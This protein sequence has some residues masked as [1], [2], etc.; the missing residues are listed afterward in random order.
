MTAA[1]HIA[2]LGLGKMGIPMVRNLLGSGYAV[3]VYNRSPEPTAMLA[4]EGAQL[5]SSPAEAVKAG[6]IAIT[7]LA[8]DAALQTVTSGS[9]GL[10]AGL[11]PGGLHIS[12]STVSP[13]TSRELAA[14]HDA[15]A[16]Q[17]LTAPVF[18]RPEAA[19]ARK[20]WI[21]QSGSQA[22]KTRAHPLLQALGQGI[23]DFGDAPEA[24]SVVKLAGNFMILSAIEAM[25]EAFALAEKQG[26]DRQALSALFGQ[27]LF[28][29]PVYQNYGRILAERAYTP[30]GF[31]LELGMKDMRL[32]RDTAEQ[33]TVTMP[34]ADL[35]HARLLASLAKGRAD[36]DWTAIELLTAEDAALR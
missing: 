27:T 16:C 25:S 21:C 33:A 35:L 12:M 30:A 22:A 34:L 18:G 28:A 32:V 29:C 26:I 3:T 8:N 6:G 7:M 15:A 23:F 14:Q 17:F 31:K 1:P 4:A 10:L 2:F 36:M 24:A 19:A 13:D 20:L 5:A 11:G 9:T